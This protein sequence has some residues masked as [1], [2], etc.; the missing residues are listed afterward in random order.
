MLFGPAVTRAG[1]RPAGN[2]LQ[3]VSAEASAKDSSNQ[4]Q[5][6]ANQPPAFAVLVATFTRMVMSAG[7]PI[8]VT[9][10][11]DHAHIA[12]SLVL[13]AVIR[14]LHQQHAA[15][16]PQIPSSIPPSNESPSA[17]ATTVVVSSVLRLP[18]VGP[19]RGRYGEPLA[20]GG[21]RKGIEIAAHA[22]EIVAAPAAGTIVFAGPFRGY[23]LLLII[24]H[25]EGYHTLMAGMARVDGAIGQSVDAG[26]PVGS[27]S[28]A[29]DRQP[30]L[31]FEV[32]RN[33]QPIDPLP[34]LGIAEAKESG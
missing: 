22:G 7:T 16:P 31:V 17:M 13:G 23:G 14:A 9:A 1:D 27:M 26:E 6:F 24:K 25:G 5:H 34:L 4:D 21:A 19:L 18:V 33:G 32:W 28:V 30:A 2:G 12:A 20:S 15:V 8:G 3:P 29:N 10:S 11:V